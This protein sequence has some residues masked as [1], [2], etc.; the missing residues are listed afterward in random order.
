SSCR[1][2]RCT[3]MRC[4]HACCAEGRRR[5]YGPCRYD[6][7]RCLWRG[8]FEQITRTTPWRLMIL[9]PSHIF[10]TEARTFTLRQLPDLAMGMPERHTEPDEQPLSVAGMRWSCRLRRGEDFGL[11]AG[12][13]DRVFVVGGQGPV[14]GDD[15]PVVVQHFGPPVA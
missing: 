6:P 2:R 8:F 15:G 10:F 1:R 4:R 9:H 3:S 14:D 11:L 5:R 7:C 13:N 12:H